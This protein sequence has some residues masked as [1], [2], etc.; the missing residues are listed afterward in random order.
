MSAFQITI[1][2]PII[3]N[4]EFLNSLPQMLDSG[5]P[6]LPYFPVRILLPMGEVVDEVFIVSSE[7]QTVYSAKKISHI[8]MMQPI[9]EPFKLNDPGRNLNIYNANEF[10]PEN[11]FNKL[12]TQ[13]MNGYQILLIN[14]YPY[15]YNPVTNEVSWSKEMKVSY[16]SHFDTTTM[17][18]QNRFL[19]NKNRAVND[20][21]ELLINPQEMQS[22]H[23]SAIS[24]DRNLPNPDQPFS[25]VIITTNEAVSYF[26]EFVNW[27][28]TQGISTG[29][30]TTE[31]IY[32]NYEGQDDQE[33]VRN[34]V[35][36]AYATYSASETPLEYVLLG[37][38]DELVPERGTFGEVGSY[39]DYGIPCD[40]Y[41]GNLDGDWDANGNNVF[42]ETSDDSDLMPEVAVGR[43]TCETETEF[44][45]FFQKNYTYVDDS[46]VSND[47][48]Y[49]IGENLNNNPLTWGG[50]Y[51]DEIEE[52]LENGF[53]LFRLYDRDG[54]FSSS[55]VR[56]AIN[57]GLSIINHMGHANENMVMGQTLGSLS[58]YDN[59]EFGFVYSQ[60]CY[61]AAFDEA[62]SGAS[63]SIA[64]NLILSSHALYA[65][66]GNTRY[67]WYY[68]GSTDGASQFFSREFFQGLFQ[69]NQR[70]LGNA[71]N[72]SK[73]QLINDAMSSSVMRWCY[74]ELSVLGDP[75]VS[76]KS[77]IGSFPYIQPVSS[78]FD[79]YLGDSDGMINPGETININIALEN[80]E[81]W[82]NA[83][84]VYAK[85]SF[86]NDNVELVQ[87]S[88]YY[89]S[90]DDGDVSNGYG[91]FIIN[92]SQSC[93]YESINYNLQVIAPISESA[94]FERN[95]NLSFEISLYQANW[96]WYANG[97]VVSNPAIYDIDGDLAM[98]S[99]IAKVD[100]SLHLLD[101]N[102]MDLSDWPLEQDE[103]LWRSFAI[104]DLDGDSS[105]D[106]VFASR[107]GI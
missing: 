88:V 23:K 29:I 95:Y 12:G 76:V 68:P 59:S 21:S 11:D 1:P 20:L 62:T 45:N 73:I 81:G 70:Q 80:L 67:G 49:F 61:P 16:S 22:Y 43:I 83:S 47:I 35:I 57:G 94:N 40:M 101:E 13:F 63:E 66:V 82:S 6:A 90:I 24:Y 10:Y 60:G 84:D 107:N 89:G 74:Y 86:E 46:N 7:H 97:A 55:N 17:E 34:F 79:D 65:F 18:Q 5:A 53:H 48:T 102:V 105:V 87:D 32:E 2:E 37:G 100:A 38:D 75:S 52:Y 56:D 98:E 14:L 28:N 54:T 3:E 36:D 15:K 44:Q 27:K 104:A 91:S 4:G 58:S 30:F 26:E 42:G 8:P 93:G 51:T 106:F 85:I 69:H 71:N 78:S 50:D 19:L 9:S 77:P 41:Y 103:Y 25:M 72:Y 96:P 39:V 92:V 64:E 33:K 31:D 99:I